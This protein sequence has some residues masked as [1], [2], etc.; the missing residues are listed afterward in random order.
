MDKCFRP[1]N[2]IVSLL[3]ACKEYHDLAVG[4]ARH[5]LRMQQQEHEQRERLETMVEQLAKQQCALEQQALRAQSPQGGGTGG[6][7]LSLNPG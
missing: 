5:W 3:Q 2:Y 7:P 6:P 1:V 4:Q